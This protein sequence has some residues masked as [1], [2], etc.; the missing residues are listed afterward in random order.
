MQIFHL[1]TGLA[2]KKTTSL[3]GTSKKVLEPAWA[4]LALLKLKWLSCLLAFTPCSPQSMDTGLVLCHQ[5]D[6]EEMR[7]CDFG[8]QV[9]KDTVALPCSS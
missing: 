1:V 6:V 2:A 5:E 7:E 9:V 4:T 8:G 3:P